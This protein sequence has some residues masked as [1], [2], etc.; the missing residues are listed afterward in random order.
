MFR[1]VYHTLYDVTSNRVKSERLTSLPAVLEAGLR[2]ADSDG[3]D[4][5]SMRRL[6]DELG[7]GA[8]T[9]YSY[10]RTKE[11]LLDGIAGLVLTEL[12][13][14]DPGQES[15]QERLEIAMHQLHVA[16]VQHPGV[17]QI[18][19]S[20]QAPI[21]ALD[22]FRETL[23]AILADAG[24]P[25]A[26]AVGIV[27]ALACYASGFAQFELHRTQVKPAD[28]AARL[29]RLPRTDFPHLSETADAYAG[30]LSQDAF[31]FG[32]RSFIRGLQT[33]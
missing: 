14:D 19:V 31:T 11:E 27:S 33:S 7:V 13:L 25:S 8:M 12:P 15:W 6:A 26:R 23:L 18:L 10:V 17:A 22:R 9:L 2:I 28:E 32:L 29:R 20:R 30:H 3:L 1:T 4:A 24:F 16:L 5:L 21:P